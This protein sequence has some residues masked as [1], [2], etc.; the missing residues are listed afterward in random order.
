MSQ[1]ANTSPLDAEEPRT[2]RELAPWL[3]AQFTLM[4]Q[5][6]SAG[7]RPEFAP[8]D[9]LSPVTQAKLLAQS[10]HE[11]VNHLEGLFVELFGEQSFENRIA[12]SIGRALLLSNNAQHFE[13]A[14]RGAIRNYCEMWREFV[15]LSS[16]T[17]IPQRPKEDLLAG[18]QH[19]LHFSRET[20]YLAGISIEETKPGTEFDPDKHQLTEKLSTS[21]RAKL[22]HIAQCQ[23]PGFVWTG[24]NGAPRREP[25][26]VAVFTE[27]VPPVRKD[28]PLPAN[29][30]QPKKPR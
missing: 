16:R 23:V 4:R 29:N 24:V 20:L 28:V 26:Q 17:D 2:I 6:V 8:E 27:L 21:D 30:G 11:A 9:A 15:R 12:Q 18:M 25:P 14:I 3:A 5:I 1:K 7:S 10:L 22:N 13:P 19:L